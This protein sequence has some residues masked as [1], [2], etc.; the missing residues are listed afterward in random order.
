MTAA[1]SVMLGYLHEPHLASSFVSS[2]DGLRTWDAT[3]DQLLGQWAAMK[4]EA[5]GIPEGRDRL[6]DAL[7]ESDCEWL[8]MV[9]SDMG[10]APDTL[11]R[12]IDAA[13]NG[14]HPIVGALCFAWR[15]TGSDGM[16]GFRHVPRPTILD[17][18]EHE[19]GV[20][21]FTG[22]ITYPPNS[23]VRCSATGAACMVIHRR[24]FEKLASS[25]LTASRAGGAP[26]WYGRVVGTDGSLLGEDVS[27]GVRCMA[28]GIPTWVHTGIKTTHQKTIY[29]A[30]EDFYASQLPPPATDR[31][32]VVADTESPEWAASLVASTGLA[33]IAT[34]PAATRDDWI[35]IPTPTTTFGPGWFDHA[36]HTARTF[37]AEFVGL[38]EGKVW[39]VARTLWDRQAVHGESDPVRVAK[40]ALHEASQKRTYAFCPAAKVWP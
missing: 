10:F 22:R 28:A 33:T 3:H 11:D 2:L 16:G 34:D 23:M 25:G 27:F 32:T 17:W 36:Q 21:R 4:C 30:E 20:K 7:L 14:T 1:G 26:S 29:V 12:L 19:D 8:F 38:A 9:D 13:D 40:W 37:D 6:V 18:F 31:V 24:V 15:E 35:V 39:M 5:G